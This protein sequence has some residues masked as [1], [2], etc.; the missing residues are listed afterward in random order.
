MKKP[1]EKESHE[2]SVEV[3]NLAM[4]IPRSNLWGKKK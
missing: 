4:S 2:F 1:R 3:I